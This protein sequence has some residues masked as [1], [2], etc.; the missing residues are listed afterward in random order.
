MTYTE[1]HSAIRSRFKTE[2]ADALELT[3]LYDNDSSGAPTDGSAWCR[4][5]ILD[6]KSR[7]IVCGVTEYRLVGAAIVQFFGPTGRGDKTL[8]SYVDTVIAAFRGQ[9]ASGVRYGDAYEQRVG[10]TAEGNYY[11]INVVCPFT[12]D[13]TE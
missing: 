9:T 8:Q 6:G 2:V 3:A 5:T 13:T 10:E 7:A 12:A 4:L 1:L 11:Q